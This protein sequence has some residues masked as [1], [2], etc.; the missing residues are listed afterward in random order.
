VRVRIL[1]EPIGVVDNIVLSTYRVGRVYD[2]PVS[3]ASYLIAENFALCEM[4]REEQTAFLQYPKERRGR[5]N[6]DR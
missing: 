3:L 6:A 4:R 1:R 5:L 2:L